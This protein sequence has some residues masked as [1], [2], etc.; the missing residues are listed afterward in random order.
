MKLLLFRYATAF[1][2]FA[3]TGA[4]RPVYRRRLAR[5]SLL[6]IERNMSYAML[7]PYR[8]IESFFLWH[9]FSDT[10]MPML[11]LACMEWFDQTECC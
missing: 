4:C 5:G 2:C 3:A 9:V 11:Q 7:L 10:L 1:E 6:S 8:G